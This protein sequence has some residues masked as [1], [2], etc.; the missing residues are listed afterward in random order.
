LTGAVHNNCRLS[1]GQAFFT[2]A[3]TRDQDQQDVRA[4]VPKKARKLEHMA[5]T[6]MQFTMAQEHQKV[7]ETTVPW[8]LGTLPSAYFR[9][10]SEAT[11]HQHLRAVIALK[12]LDQDI[13]LTLKSTN[14]STGDVDVT[15]MS[16]D[17]RVGALHGML[18]KMNS[19]QP[20]S[21]ATSLVRVKVFSSYDN[22]LAVNIFTYGKR[23]QDR[24]MAGP[25]DGEALFN[26]AVKEL[27][28]S[29]PNLYGREALTEYLKLC[30]P[31]Y[32]KHAHPPT[33]LAQRAMY[34]QVSGTEGVVVDVGAHAVKT[35]SGK[36]GELHGAW[37]LIAAAN[38]LPRAFLSRIAAFMAGR[39]LNVERLHMDLVRDPSN[40]MGGGWQGS[41]A[42]IRAL[43]QPTQDGELPENTRAF[44]GNLSDLKTGP[45][46]ELKRDLE[47]IKWLDEAAIHLALWKAPA[48]GMERAEILT[49]M[50]AMLH[51]PLNKLNPHVFS[52]SKMLE[53][54]GQ[55]VHTKEALSIA[56]LFLARFDPDG[57]LSGQEFT[58]TADQ[59]QTRIGNV[60]DEVA[61]TLLLKMVDVVR[62]TLRTNFFV[63]NRY[64]LA[65]R[66]DPMLMVGPG[67]ERLPFG[68]IF[69]HGW[70][71]DAFH[72]RFQNIARG[73]LR[74]V[75]PAS[76]E[77]YSVESSRCYD[78]VY[79]LSYAQQLK[80]KDIPEGGSKAVVLVDVVTI[81][82]AR[83]AMV[84]RMAVKAFTDAVLD[85]I[86]Q[87][88]D[89]RSRIVD[90]LGFEEL[91]YL[92]PDEQV[93]ADDINWIVKRAEQR[94]YPCPS[95][96]MSSKPLAGI[97]HKVYGVTS[98]GVVVF[99]DMALRRTGLNPKEKPFTVKITGGPDGDVA[100][101]LIKILFRDYGDN[102]RI[103][104]VS[105]GFGVAEDPDGLPKEELLRLV[106]DA[107]PIAHLDPAMLSKTGSLH[108]ADTEE[109]LRRR[110]SMHNR[111]MADIFVP[112]GGR[113]NTINASNWRE[114]LIP[115][116]SEPSSKLIVEGANIF[117]TP[118]ARAALFENA[119]VII[120]KDSSANKCGVITSSYE[121]CASMLLEEQEFL[122]VKDELVQDVLQRL[123]DLARSEAELLFR[124]YQNFPGSLP[125][126][127]ERISQS[128]N[129]AKAAIGVHLAGMALDDEIFHNLLPLFLTEHLPRKLAEVAG[130]RVKDR[131]PISYLKNA[132]ASS[133]A[134]KLLYCEGTHFLESQPDERLAS[135]A[136]RY[137]DREKKVKDLVKT[138]D[139]CESLD[140][141][142]RSEVVKLLKAG[143]AR[144]SLQAL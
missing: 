116:T 141:G 130:D 56:D 97:N 114:F 37:V 62:R 70:L 106:N 54:L 112:A 28:G 64:A 17:A 144:S 117:I 89:T 26:H 98:E 90:H 16:T 94:G 74:I 138:V 33:F 12:G 99:L 134:S 102:A 14:M 124:E 68:T 84:L 49:A 79:G 61:H 111:V 65:F 109:G 19:V 127:S 47:R 1:F 69:V 73:G 88:P 38:V 77:Q 48:L 25:D 58:S 78:E 85:L 129:R 53:V 29:D 50:V 21:E 6:S 71:V 60:G 2:M 128:I 13:Q 132:F 41:V 123:R 135:L 75:S 121:I 107:L 131:I 51:G 143:G 133:L 5:V 142:T 8:F 59:L 93:I 30:E 42:M 91:I 32:V 104:G 35:E 139:A 4:W 140:P 105:D 110:N 27:E 100:G 63:R 52:R 92:G 122:A 101:N 120:V 55:P 43:V 46:K 72:N 66:L 83:K 80:N 81:S 34:T 137:Y 45:W 67:Q 96:F 39:G 108:K 44:G 20:P 18:T 126:V 76:A 118:E 15:F 31:F 87:A 10:V 113:P 23:T 11:R 115:G 125:L 24:Q 86:V 9:E 119:G 82:L 36:D 7:A 136:L 40:S 95:A 57:P 22:S 103:V 3:H